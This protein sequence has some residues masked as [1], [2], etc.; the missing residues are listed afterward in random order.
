MPHLHIQNV[1]MDVL[2]LVRLGQKIFFSLQVEDTTH[3][4]GVTALK[5]FIQILKIKCKSMFVPIY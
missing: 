3:H 1:F 4:L 5:T 2:N